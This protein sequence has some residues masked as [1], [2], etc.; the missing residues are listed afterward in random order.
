MHINLFITHEEGSTEVYQSLDM[1]TSILSLFKMVFLY[2][3]VKFYIHCVTADQVYYVG[4]RSRG[5]YYNHTCSG[6]SG[7]DW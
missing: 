1:I 6:K 4:R 5:P 2:V 3:R 7:V